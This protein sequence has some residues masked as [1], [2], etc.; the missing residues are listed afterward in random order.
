MKLVVAV[1][2]EEHLLYCDLILRPHNMN[3]SYF[4]AGPLRHCSMSMSGLVNFAAVLNDCY[5]HC[6]LAR[7]CMHSIWSN[8][9][10]PPNSK[11]RWQQRWLDVWGDN[12]LFTQNLQTSHGECQLFYNLTALS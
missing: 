9:S 4:T 2:H 7:T 3:V 6:R 12:L 5:W 10:S 1:N 8:C 11:W